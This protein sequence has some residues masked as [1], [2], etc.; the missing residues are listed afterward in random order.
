MHR[1]LYRKR[2]GFIQQ[3]LMGLAMMVLGITTVPSIVF[4][5][6]ANP[7]PTK[8]VPSTVALPVEISIDIATGDED[9]LPKPA[10]TIH[11]INAKSGKEVDLTLPKSNVASNHPSSAAARAPFD[12]PPIAT[13][14][15]TAPSFDTPPVALG[16]VEAPPFDAPPVVTPPLDIPVADLPPIDPPTVDA[17]PVATPPVDVPAAG[18]P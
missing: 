18:R 16:A 9:A 12:T 8:K 13:P 2:T 17:P 7:D 4:G 5:E 11:M 10:I 15:V 3:W 6:Q 14:P 1:T